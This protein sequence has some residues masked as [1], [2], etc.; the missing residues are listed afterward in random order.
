[1]PALSYQ[2]LTL[3][4]LAALT[5]EKL[6]AQ[7]TLVDEGVMKFDYTKNHYDI[8]GISICTSSSAR[9]YELADFFKARGSYVMIGGHHATLLPEEAAQHADSVFLGSAELTLPAFFEDYMNGV[10]KPLYHTGGVHADKIPVPRRDLM[11]KK[12]YLKPPTIVADYGCGNSCRYCVIHSFWGNSA[13]RPVASVVDEIKL[14][15]A[16]EYLFLDPSPLSNRAYAKELFEALI[17]LNIKWAGLATLDI[18]DDEELLASMEKSGCIG[19]LLGFE[20]F[21]A[22]DLSSMNKYKNKVD[23]YCEITEKL[24]TYG[25]AILGTFMLGFDGETKESIRELPDLIA[26][27]KID[28][29]RYAI[30][31]PYPATPLFNH[32]ENQ[33]RILHKD[34]SKYDSIHCVFRPKNMTAYELEQEHL[35][36]WKDTYKTGK[37]LD[38]LRFT[39]QRKG[40]A[41][42]TNFGFKIYARRLQEL[43]SK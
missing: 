17:P 15:G 25:I 21:N 19:T 30:L 36:V 9:G 20:T 13:R 24:R 7:I 28:V 6:N 39:P 32:L 40:T 11:P 16:K 29:P 43:I 14:L 3:S 5:P 22:D 4:T 34:W 12:G 41:L 31:T 27:T 42:I 2:S 1:M 38:R 23:E 18:A 37:I 26:K 10:P 33:N 8:V 35:K